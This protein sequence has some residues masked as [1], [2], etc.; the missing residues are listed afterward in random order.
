MNVLTDDHLVFYFN[1]FSYFFH[2]FC[3]FVTVYFILIVSF[4][5]CVAALCYF[6]C[7]HKLLRCPWTRF[8]LVLKKGPN[9][10]HS[11]FIITSTILHSSTSLIQFYIL[12]S[13]NIVSYGQIIYNFDG[14]GFQDQILQHAINQRVPCTL[15]GKNTNYNLWIQVSDCKTINLKFLYNL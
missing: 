14:F 8:R 9:M 15:N 5:L 10:M 11:L 2:T 3:L 7:F 13:V 1:L 6:C 12:F 4:C